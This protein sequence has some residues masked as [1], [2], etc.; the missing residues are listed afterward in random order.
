MDNINFEF[1][2]ALQLNSNHEYDRGVD[3]KQKHDQN[4]FY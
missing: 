2:N 1:Q 4:S 3:E